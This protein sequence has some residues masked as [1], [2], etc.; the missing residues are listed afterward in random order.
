MRHKLS[1]ITPTL[2][3][4]FLIFAI[5]HPDNAAAS[6]QIFVQTL[7]G[8][9]ITLDV[10]S[11]D[12]IENVKQKIQDKEGLPPDQQRLTFGDLQLEDGRT[13]AD[14][15]IQKESTLYLTL[16]TDRPPTVSMSL[17]T[18]P[19]AGKY[20]A[21]INF[22]ETV[23]GFEVSD[24]TI[25][26]GTATV[27]GT[28]PSYMV[29][30]TPGGEGTT[31]IQVA[32]GAAV[33]IA[34]NQS[35][36]SNQVSAFFDLSGP[37]IAAPV[38]VA[39]GTDAGQNTGLATFAATVSDNSG[40]TVTPVYKLG[41]TVISSPHSFVVGSHTVT[42]D[43]SDS[44]GNAATQVSFTVTVS[45]NEAPVVTVPENIEVNAAAGSNTATVD[46]TTPA[47][48]DA[49][50]GTVTPVLVSSPMVGLDSGSAFPIGVTTLTY[51]ATDA[52][53]NVGTAS[54]TVTVS[55]NEA[56]VVT[57]PDSIE[58]N[59]AAGSDTALVDFTAPTA[60]DAV[61]GTINPVLVSSP[62]VGLDSG[63]AFPIG[64][65]TL[66][67]TATDVVGNVGTASFTVTVSD[68][69]APVVTVPENISV[70][71]AAGSDTATV[72]FTAPTATDA[73]D[74]TVTPVL[75]SSPTEG[76]DS[77][78]SFPTGVTILTYTATDVV[79]TAAMTLWAA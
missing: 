19:V 28:G 1:K 72:S 64:V 9:I 63:S 6:M 70:N 71:A 74:G 47:A 16:R 78:S 24:L 79:G 44:S 11:S 54:F 22:D 67:Y 42:M 58:V 68:N 39:L 77:G 12:S 30:L 49:V 14:Y 50:D 65:T 55:D 45:D 52:A 62:T 4:F 13:L 60:T 25:V 36:A 32:A 46:F 53:G 56:P 37:I 76:L 41:G 26:N 61:D 27:S 66:T 15:G 29:T 5:F 43:A 20:T 38:D 18:G 51:T 75:V 40:E 35:L 73:V 17:L 31:S 10:E 34:S 57:V 7:A 21:T 48:I 8:E 2:A 59:A 33:D 3:A 23:T 69:E